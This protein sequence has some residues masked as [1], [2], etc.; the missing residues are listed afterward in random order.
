MAMQFIAERYLNAY[1]DNVPCRAAGIAQAFG[2]ASVLLYVLLFRYSNQL[3]HLAE[4][5]RH[6][7]KAFFAMP[8]GLALLFSLVHG[9]FTGHFWDAMGLKPKND[10]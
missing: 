7:H 9:K 3:V 10:H 8:I 5:T 4:L 2:Y 1:R 6:G